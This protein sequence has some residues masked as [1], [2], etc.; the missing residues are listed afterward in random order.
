MGGK[1][2]QLIDVGGVIGGTSDVAEK[3]NNKRVRWGT[4]QPVEET[5][6][7]TVEEAGEGGT[8][9]GPRNLAIPRI[10]GIPLPSQPNQTHT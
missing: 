4:F 2:S 8:K 10:T 9:V 5:V 1:P 3:I 6:E 7:E